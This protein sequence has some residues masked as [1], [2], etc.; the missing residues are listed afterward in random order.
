MSICQRKC[1]QKLF[2]RKDYSCCVKCE[3][4]SITSR[5]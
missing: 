5:G 4:N 2:L 3:Y 1:K